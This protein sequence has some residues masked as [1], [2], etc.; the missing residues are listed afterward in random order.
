MVVLR[1]PSC[2]M[3]SLQL[4]Y[5]DFAIYPLQQMCHKIW[6]KGKQCTIVWYMDNAKVLHES[7]SVIRDIISEIEKK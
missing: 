4:H 1:L 6:I 7:P 5:M 3:N 2:G